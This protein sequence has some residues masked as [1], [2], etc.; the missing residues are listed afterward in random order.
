[1]ASFD[2]AEFSVNRLEDLNGLAGWTPAI[3]VVANDLVPIVER[4]SDVGKDPIVV[5]SLR[6]VLDIGEDLAPIG[7]RVPKQLEDASRHTGMSDDTVGGADQ[8]GPI[9]TGNAAKDLVR[10]RDM[11][12][13]VSFADDHFLGPE[14]PLHASGHNL[15]LKLIDRFR[16]RFQNSAHPL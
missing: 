4:G 11:T 2:L 12:L 7:D 9:I 14:G 6:H 16:A 1:M 13:E 3:R 8:V 5:A 10:I 15:T